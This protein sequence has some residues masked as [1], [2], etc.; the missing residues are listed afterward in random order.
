M[1]CK[2]FN[3]E[4]RICRTCPYKNNIHGRGVPACESRPYFPSD[5]KVVCKGPITP[6]KFID[7]DK[8]GSD[9]GSI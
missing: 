5:Q 6:A 1:N 3:A 7:L 9:S 2:A 4:S 8:E